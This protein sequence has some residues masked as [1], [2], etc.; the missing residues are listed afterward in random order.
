MSERSE[1]TPCN[2]NNYNIVKLHVYI[3]KRLMGETCSQ[4]AKGR[5]THV[6]ITATKVKTRAEKY[7]VNNIG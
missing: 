7:L 3:T 4:L 1:L 6:L 5:H 2:V